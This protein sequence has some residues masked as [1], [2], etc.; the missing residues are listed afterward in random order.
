MGKLLEEGLQLE[1][2]A[3]YVDARNPRYKAVISAKTDLTPLLPYLNAVARVVYYDPEEPVLIFRLGD[4]KVAVRK[5]NV[6]ISNLT[7][8]EE[9]RQLREE[10]ERF[11]TEVWEKRGEISPRLEPR[12]LPPALEIYRCLPGTNCGECGEPSCMAFAVKLSTLEAEPQACRPLY[13]DPQF[14][15]KRAALQKLLPQ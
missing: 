13:Q 7:D 11:L 12:R 10:V 15:E 5:D 9:A 1:P 3:C 8:Q 6:Q 14:A 2:V 4:N